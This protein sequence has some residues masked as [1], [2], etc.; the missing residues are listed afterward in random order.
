MRVDDLIGYYFATLLSDPA[1]RL[2]HT[3]DEEVGHHLGV[4]QVGVLC[5]HLVSRIRLYQLFN[6]KAGLDQ[7]VDPMAQ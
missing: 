2:A 6:L 4:L 1:G 5:H 3:D 7:Q